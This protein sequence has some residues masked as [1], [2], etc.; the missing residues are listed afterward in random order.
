MMNRYN[1]VSG[2]KPAAL[3]VGLVGLLLSAAACGSGD[4]SSSSSPPSGTGATTGL[5]T[6]Q[7]PASGKAL[8]IFFL[9]EEGASAAAS[10]PENTQAADAAVQYVNKNLGGINGRP[11]EL[12]RCATLGTPDSA[13]NCAN[14]AVDAKPDVFVKGVETA[15]GTAVPIITGAGIPYVTRNAGNA[16]ELT[17]KNAFSL[18]GGFTAQLA[19]PIDYAKSKGIKSIGVIYAEVPSLTAAVTTIGKLAQQDGLDYTKL[20]VAATTADLTP[21]YN[22]LLAKKVGAIY[23][24]TTSPQCASALK[25]RS[26]LSDTTPLF[27]ATSCAVNSVLTSVPPNVTNGSFAALSDTS[28]DATDPDTKIYR[29]AMKQ[30]E[31]SA[32]I[33]SFAPTSFATIMDLYDVLKTVP[34][35]TTL[36]AATVT[37]TLQTA[38]GTHLF[39]GGDKTFTCDGSAFPTSPSVCTGAAFLVQYNNGAFKVVGGYDSS[40]LLKGL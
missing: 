22:T 14:Q 9:N 10:A 12:V 18:S 16:A 35:P 1:G 36:N 24:V 19:P 34:D 5:G 31:P 32:S 15:I 3:A 29:A 30:Y 37:S 23:L 33:G 21:A 6:P 38:K 26:T 11:L 7:K 13:T 2:I 17:T 40:Q 25:A 28:A 4:N 39:M 8:R 27:M 20:P